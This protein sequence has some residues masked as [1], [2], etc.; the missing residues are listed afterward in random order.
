VGNSADTQRAAAA[1]E[2]L[3]VDTGGEYDSRVVEALG[4]LVV[5]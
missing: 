5:Q 2:W 1:M 3:H 4:R